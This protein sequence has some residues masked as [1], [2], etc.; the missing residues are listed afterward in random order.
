[1]RL[2]ILD[3]G[4]D[5]AVLEESVLKNAFVISNAAACAECN[6]TGTGYTASA[7]IV[8][9]A[10]WAMKIKNLSATALAAGDRIWCEL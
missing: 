9:G 8:A 3:S 1:M 10:D 6:Q 5:Y 4:N 7:S 2:A